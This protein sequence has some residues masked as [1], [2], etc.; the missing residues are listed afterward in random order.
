MTL[1]PL[2]EIAPDPMLTIA[3]MCGL[4]AVTPRTLRFYEAKKLIFPVRQGQRRLYT[5]RCRARLTLILQG[6][7][8]GF[9]LDEIGGL[10]E[11]YDRDGS[12][13]TQLTRTCAI[14]KDRL[15]RMEQ[16]RIELDEAIAELKGEL[17][18]GAGVIASFDLQ[19]AA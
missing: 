13:I 9:S 4:F 2:P 15:A 1:T 10:L 16:Q 11:L 14:A 3:R 8:F 12:Q 5:R 7:R 17:A 19:P 18:W 6:K